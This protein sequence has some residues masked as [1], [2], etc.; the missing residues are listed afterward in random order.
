MSQKCI[1]HG[2]KEEI[3]DEVGRSQHQK[4]NIRDERQAYNSGK[5]QQGNEQ[6]IPL[7]MRLLGQH[8]P[9]THGKEGQRF[10]DSHRLVQHTGNHREDLAASAEVRRQAEP[11]QPVGRQAGLGLSGEG[12][13]R[14]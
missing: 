3:E 6:K 10:I 13:R 8:A 14:L 2:L 12:Q 7:K 11:H 4:S 9:R 5:Y 1:V